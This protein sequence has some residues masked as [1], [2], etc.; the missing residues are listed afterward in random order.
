[1]AVAISRGFS[2]EAPAPVFSAPGG[3]FTNDVTLSL[4]APGAV[5]RY[6]LDGSA[7]DE[8]SRTATGPLAITN[9]AL[10]RARSFA[11]GLTPSETVSHSFTLLG[12]DLIDFNSNL[13]LVIVNAHHEEVSH[14]GRIDVALCVIETSGGRAS[15]LGKSD[16]D[17]RGIV[18]IRGHASLRYPKHSYTLRT[19]DEHD[20]KRKSPILGLAKE[21]EWILY[22]PYPDKT[23]MRDV[24]AYELSN[25]LDQWAPKTRY[26]ELFYN[27]DG[28]RLT[29]SNYVG[30]YV[31]EDRVTRGKHRVDIERLGP[32][33]NTEP[34]I[35]GGYLLKKDHVGR[36]QRAK[37]P[38]E[39]PRLGA[40]PPA[41]ERIA[42]PSG[43]GGFPADPAGF[44]NAASTSAREAQR[45]AGPLLRT[46]RG[47]QVEAVTNYVGFSSRPDSGTDARRKYGDG[48][49][50]ADSDGFWTGLDGQ[51]LFYV[52]PEPDELTALQRTWLT[53]HF[54]ELESALYGPDF[55]DPQR[56]Y[57]KFID[58][59]SFIDHHLLVEVSKNVDGFRFS[60]FYHLDRGGKLHLGPLWDLNL[61]FGNAHS[62]ECYRPEG[63][64]WPH[65]DNEGYSYFRR[66]FEDPDFA[67]RYADRWAEL[68]ANVFDT[69]NVLARVDRIAAQLNEAQRRNFVR[70]PILGEEIKPN[71]FVGTNYTAE[72]AWMK[73]WIAGRLDWMER[74]FVA[75]PAA[76]VSGSAP[77]RQL[78]FKPIAGTKIYYTLDGTDPRGPDGGL[79]PQAKLYEAAVP[80]TDGA[81]LFARSQTDLRW[82][83]PTRAAR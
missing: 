3:V 11:P 57:A 20:D 47:I 51:H 80:L 50:T 60:T 77:Q 19:I 71:Y 44:T 52:E 46:Q 40:N 66:L 12:D 76:R 56:G 68:R 69:S 43:P 8:T 37:A 63:W 21:N 70:W 34:E 9:S 17:G 23:L 61:S 72:I 58:A 2:V 29:M 10:V 35:S 49:I 36:G 32:G 45:R 48:E 16:F 33:D 67:Q 31:F 27:A 81:H 14:E 64:L 1:M 41:Q 59:G 25:A 74:Q 75:A 73:D 55:R 6:T 30:V 83:G 24:L 82:S 13:P 26:V 79:S 54:N 28:G 7:P 39:R 4:S 15:L 65:L 78:E 18:N 22:A 53:K 62:Y 38:A 42:L 5:V